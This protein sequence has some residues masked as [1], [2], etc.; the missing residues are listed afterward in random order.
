[1]FRGPVPGWSGDQNAWDQARPA[2]G[3][4]PGPQHQRGGEEFC[5]EVSCRPAEGYGLPVMIKAVCGLAGHVECGLGGRIWK[6]AT[7]WAQAQ[8]ALGT[9]RVALCGEMH[10]EPKH[11][12]DFG[13]MNM[14]PQRNGTCPCSIPASIYQNIRYLPNPPRPKLHGRPSPKPA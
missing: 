10:P 13:E 12:P 1:M 7:D 14:G 11:S 6:K 8:M 4:D 5:R 9:V 3:G 2:E